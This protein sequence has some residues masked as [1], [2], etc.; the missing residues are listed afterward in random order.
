MFHH[1]RI[2]YVIEVESIE[3]LAF[4][5]KKPTDLSQGF[6]VAG[7]PDYLF[8][9]DSTGNDDCFTEY[10]VI[11][12][13]LNTTHRVQIESLTIDY[14]THKKLAGYIKTTLAGAWDS[15]RFSK[16]PCTETIVGEPRTDL[17]HR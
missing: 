13:G 6:S 9:N 15:R 2:W 1:D 5:I 3:A 4:R 12:G 8:L 10:A 17:R 11:K 7:H 16:E 14:C